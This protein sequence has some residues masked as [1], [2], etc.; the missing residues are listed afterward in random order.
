MSAKDI[1]G[2]PSDEEELEADPALRERVEQY[3]ARLAKRPSAGEV[4]ARRNRKI[5]KAVREAVRRREAG[6][7]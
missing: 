2:G 6:V 1:F 5:A 3:W 4:I 7:E